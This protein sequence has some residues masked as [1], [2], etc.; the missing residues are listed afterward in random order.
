M[1]VFFGLFYNIFAQKNQKQAA[2]DTLPTM[3]L[4]DESLQA[5]LADALDEMYNFQFQ[6]AERKFLEVRK[7]YPTHPLPYFIMGLSNWWKMMPNT[8]IEDFDKPFLAYMDTAIRTAEKL[9][10]K[11]PKNIEASFFLAAAYGFKGRLHSDREQWIKA[12]SAGRNALKYL[13]RGK[14]LND[15]SPEFMF[16]DGLFNYYAVW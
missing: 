13:R 14:Q 10:A 2:L 15:L 7:R 8:N 11:E 3:L 12:A 5:E 4:L 9:Y 6:A 16:G 1:I